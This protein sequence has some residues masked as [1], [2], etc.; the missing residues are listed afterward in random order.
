M[1]T[2]PLQLCRPLDTPLKAPDLMLGLTGITHAQLL[3]RAII[4]AIEVR[5]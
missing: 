5:L 1:C 2:Y 4:G 3:L